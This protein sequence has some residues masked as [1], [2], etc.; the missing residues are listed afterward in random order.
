MSFL[1]CMN[2]NDQVERSRAGGSAASRYGLTG[3]V[4][5]LKHPSSETK[6]ERT[7]VTK[8]DRD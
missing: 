2:L 4:L 6:L 5:S 7:C 3:R 1:S 8:E